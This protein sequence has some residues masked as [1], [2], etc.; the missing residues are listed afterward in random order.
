MRALAQDDEQVA[1]W[2]R[3][4]RLGVTLC[5]VLPLIIALRTSLS[6]APAHPD[7]VLGLAAAVAFASPLILLLPVAR[8]VRSPR[9]RLFF[10][11]WEA[12]GVGL[13]VAFALLDGGLSSPYVL[14]FFVLLAHAALAYPP[15]GMVVAGAG[16]LLGYLTVG[17]LTDGARGVDLLAG[18]LVLV[19]ATGT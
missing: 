17:L 13:T 10:D 14:I 16:N 2:E 19:V 4:T 9:G 12:V 1:F 6:D 15:V 5:V 3:H 11:G 8:M 18:S 7:A